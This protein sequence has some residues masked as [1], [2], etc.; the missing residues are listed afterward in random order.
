MKTAT[1]TNL[2][3]ALA[4]GVAAANVSTTK[5]GLGWGAGKADV[6]QF[7]Q[8]GT[9]SW[10][11]LWTENDWVKY[12]GL[13]F[14]PMLWGERDV[15]NFTATINNTLAASNVTHILGFNEPNLE[16]QSN[17]TP[18]KG[19]ELWK[20]YIQPLKASHNLTLVSPVPTNGPTGTVWLQNFINVCGTDCTI[21]KIALHYYGTNASALIEYVQ[22]V[23][24]MF[25]K[26]IWMT[27]FACQSFVDS[28]DVATAEQISA[29]MNQTV[30]FFESTP[31]VERYAWFGVRTEMP[32]M[33]PL[34]AL[35]DNDG[36]IDYLGLQYIGM[37]TWSSS[38]ASNSTSNTTDT[39]DS[40]TQ[41]PNTAGS[42][43]F[44]PDPDASG[45][46]S[47][48]QNGGWPFG[49]GVALSSSQASALAALLAGIA[50]LLL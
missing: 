2:L 33:N 27:E 38:S 15:Q 40:Q 4:S 36:H 13:E 26:P 22:E 11:Y 24:E 1:A 37:G 46:S 8:A 21:D 3:V 39:A 25:Q 35:L 14:V 28:E 47:E 7:L 42:P 45:V 50:V 43:T 44:V 34:N 49:G 12:P 31:Y 48:D 29:F 30:E 41:N 18:E 20:A 17:L 9:V 16:D 19:A 23:Y 6:S 5:V 10:Y 32:G